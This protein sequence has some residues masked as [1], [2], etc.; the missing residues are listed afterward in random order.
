[1]GGKDGVPY[2]VDRN[3][4][5]ESIEFLKIGIESANIGKKDKIQAFRRLHN[6][7]SI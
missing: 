3:A 5:D 7:I 2:P 1:M 4:M 6:F